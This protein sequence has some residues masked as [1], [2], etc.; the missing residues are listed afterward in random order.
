MK[1]E[2]RVADSNFDRVQARRGLT[3][4]NQS[5][6]NKLIPILQMGG[7]KG[8]DEAT[9]T[10]RAET[11]QKELLKLKAK[12]QRLI[13]SVARLYVV[14]ADQQYTKLTAAR[15]RVVAIVEE[16]A[17]VGTTKYLRACLNELT[18]L[19][20]GVYTGARVDKKT[21][22]LL[23]AQAAIARV[24]ALIAKSQ[25][26]AQKSA[27]E[28]D[29]SNDPLFHDDV[30]KVIKRSQDESK[31]LQSLKDKDFVLSRVP[32]VAIAASGIIDANRLTNEGFEAESLGGYP[33][34][35]NQL[36]LGI[37]PKSIQL[38][39]AQATKGKEIPRDKWLE[40]ATAIKKLI[41]KKTKQKL[42]FVDDRPHGSSGGAW[43]W[44]MPD[45][46]INGFA[47]AFPG[48]AVKLRQWGF[49][50]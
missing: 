35:H 37:N 40:T 28:A 24:D 26:R 20:E 6:L 42:H 38:T 31:Q 5:Q 25:E 8:P 10:A 48:K 14:P 46:E 13:D 44:L 21:L 29:S 4:K 9:M 30:A 50:F 16:G 39:K 47:K 43:F 11:R 2:M 45:Y 36:V 22:S 18:S 15:K 7:K 19:R 23:A 49:A 34:I 1:N 33:V 12:L 3:A 32:L 27:V 41:E 17:P